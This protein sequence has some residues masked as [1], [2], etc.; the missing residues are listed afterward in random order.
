MTDRRRAS[1]EQLL[2]LTLKRLGDLPLSGARDLAG[3]GDLSEPQLDDL[4]KEATRRDFV[5]SLKLGQTFRVQSRFYLHRKG[6]YR[7]REHLDQPITWQV[8]EPALQWHVRRLRLYE[9]VY[10]LVPCLFRSGAVRTPASFAMEPGDDPQEMVLDEHVTLEAFI[11]V[12][13]ILR[14]PVHAIAQCRTAAGDPL[15][16]PIVCVGLHHGDIP[17][18]DDLHAFFA[19]VDT[20]PDFL[21]S[22][23]PAAP[24]G[25]L[26]VV[27]DRLA[28]LA[29]RLRVPPHLPIAIVDAEGHVIRQM[30]PAAPAGR[31]L[32]PGDDPG[33][34]GQPERTREWLDG[35]PH[36]LALQGVPQRKLFERVNGFPG[37][38]TEALAGG[39]GHPSSKARAI[40]KTFS[41]TGLVAILDRRPYLE[42]G[43]RVAAAR[44]DR[45]NPNTVHA[46]LGVYTRPGSTY[47]EQQ[48]D[49]DQGVA[50]LAAL[51]GRAG[52]QAEAGWRLE[53][54][55][56]SFQI[57]PDLWVLIPAG[58]GSAMWHAVEYERSALA[59]SQ[60]N[61]KL[62]PYRTAMDEGHP[63][64]MLMVCG[65][66]KRSGRG[67]AEDW[68]AARRY[69]DA[70]DDLPM[71]VMPTHLA[72]S[73]DLAA[74]GATW[75]RRGGRV[76]IT[77]LI[78][79]VDWPVLKERI[80]TPVCWD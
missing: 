7:L 30:D 79:E 26:F 46:R 53:I 42:H 12:R 69:M 45:Q 37:S 38:P 76:P 9:P 55:Q 58:D 14:S 51:F 63:W 21:Y 29:V 34:L 71:L 43:G 75:H 50:K 4:L 67:R 64:S 44:R 72:F 1:R 73:G 23:T 36:L 18:P 6:L 10:R 33:P 20:M 54:I 19:A 39:I 52:M 25:V 48:R 62:G 31:V 66:G 16:V 17:G 40:L 70:G 8:T 2:L 47:R 80:D 11:W 56:N 3:Y 74:P 41:N 61:R 15:W 24:L 22:L 77:Q 28:G 27:L 65:R 49:H 35:Q 78:H 5:G 32:D 60:V 68:A 57:R 13:D 59:E